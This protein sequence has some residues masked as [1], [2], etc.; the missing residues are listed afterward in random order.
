MKT[1][2]VKENMIELY[3]AKKEMRMQRTILRE[4]QMTGN[5]DYPQGR[6]DELQDTLF[7]LLS[8]RMQAKGI[9]TVLNSRISKIEARIEELNNEH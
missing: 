3:L 8:L 5:N 7:F 4:P 2:Q 1:R 6:L 9:L